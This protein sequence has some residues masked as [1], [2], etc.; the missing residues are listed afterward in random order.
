LEN[1]GTE[2]V[3]V[4]RRIEE[5]DDERKQVEANGLIDFDGE[6]RFGVAGTGEAEGE[7]K[8]GDKE[9][10]GGGEGGEVVESLDGRG[11]GC[12]GVSKVDNGVIGEHEEEGGGAEKV[13]ENKSLVVWFREHEGII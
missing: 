5:E 1:A 3:V 12:L 7:R 13:D 4:G 2:D 8:T 9:K 10:E 6:P 11:R